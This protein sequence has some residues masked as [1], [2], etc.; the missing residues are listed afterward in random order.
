[1]K[2]ACHKIMKE[3]KYRTALND[4]SYQL[5][6]THKTLITACTTLQIGF[7]AF[8]STRSG[9][10]CVRVQQSVVELI[11]PSFCIFVKAY[12]SLNHVFM[13]KVK[14]VV[15]VRG[16]KR[17]LE[18]ACHLGKK[19][20]EWIKADSNREGGRERELLFF[21]HLSRDNMQDIY[22]VIWGGLFWIG[23]V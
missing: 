7:L 12:Y 20:K 9:R 22:C 21:S 13:L 4:G 11:L 15:F 3:S 17:V 5:S 10:K 19:E 1:M 14:K 16:E 6:R 8:I 18:W 23:N 2:Q